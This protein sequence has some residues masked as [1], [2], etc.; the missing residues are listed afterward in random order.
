[1]YSVSYRTNNRRIAQH[2]DG[3][4]S[5]SKTLLSKLPQIPK[6][7]INPT[8]R[9]PHILPP[10]VR[11]FVS[12]HGNEIIQSL[13]VKRTPV[14]S[15][16][17]KA[18]DIMSFGKFKQ[19]I[20]NMDYD[21][22]FHLSI[23]IN[24]KYKFDKRPVITVDKCSNE[25]DQQILNVPLNGRQLTI[26]EALNNTAQYMSDRFGSYNPRSNNCQDFIVGFL[27]GNGYGDDNV[28]NF[29]KQDIERVFSQLPSYVDKIS[30]YVAGNLATGADVL[31]H[32]HGLQQRKRRV[33]R[34]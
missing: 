18:L 3:I 13:V 32:G 21:T 6:L 14:Q 10:K 4:L 34:R 8:Q 30:N 26:S 11:Q 28:I 29:V 20:D 24:N 1:M 12:D 33:R 15:F 5:F 25:R 9:D 7:L 16:V 17:Q 19:S 2:G 23:C 22:V 27:N 31:L